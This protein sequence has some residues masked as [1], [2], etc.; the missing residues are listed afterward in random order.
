VV[1]LF[2]TSGVVLLESQ[3]RRES[4]SG[5]QVASETDTPLGRPDGGLVHGA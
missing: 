3:R 4:A 1:S 2:L 5:G